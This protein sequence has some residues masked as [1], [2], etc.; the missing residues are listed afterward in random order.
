MD[1]TG[2]AAEAPA[3]E[4]SRL[5]ALRA[6]RAEYGVDPLDVLTS[7]L[8]TFK[9]GGTRLKAKE[10]VELALGLAKLE[11]EMEKLEV[12]KQGGGGG[13][14]GGRVQVGPDGTVQVDMWTDFSDVPDEELE[15]RAR[16]KA[17]ALGFG[18]TD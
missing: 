17:E 2:A 18:G 14:S 1:G 7:E 4:V 13:R 5:A 11:M 9:E 8:K 6:Y 10:G 12:A 15:A 3:A 16:R